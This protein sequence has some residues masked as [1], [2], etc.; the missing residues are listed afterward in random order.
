MRYRLLEGFVAMLLGVAMLASPAWSTSDP[1]QTQALRYFK[2]LIPANMPRQPRVLV[3][4]GRQ[5]YYDPR[6]SISGAISCSTCHSLSSYGVDNLSTSLGHKAQPGD[7]NAPTVLNAVLNFRQFWDGRA[8]NLVEQA[9]GPILNPVEMGMPNPQLAIERI[10]TVPGYQAPFRSAFPR[11]PEPTYDHIAVAIAAFE[12][13]L[14]TPS[15][16]DRFLEG[17]AAALSAPERKGLRLF[18]DQGCASCHDGVGIGGNSFK[19]FGLFKP[20]SDR[21][22]LGRYVITKQAKDKF[23]FKVPSLRNVTRTYPYFHDGRVWQL[24]KAVQIMGETQL[25]KRLSNSDTT[26]IVAF[27][28]SLDGDLSSS[29]LRLPVLPPSGPHTPKPER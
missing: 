11:S 27:L 29:I 10:R 19:K 24:S 1:L 22:D 28:G 4:L 12:S 7:R 26:A 8:A 23:V 5:L 18:M 16:F 21:R 15:R 17:D 20:Y 2:S 14:L 3:S 13:T 9:K 6:L 25:G